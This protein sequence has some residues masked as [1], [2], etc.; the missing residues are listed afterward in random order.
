[1][2]G[3]ESYIILTNI[4]PAVQVF[5]NEI[6]LSVTES[7]MQAMVTVGKQGINERDVLV[8]VSAVTTAIDINFMA[9]GKV[10]T[11]NIHKLCYLFL[12]SFEGI[13]QI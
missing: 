7:A 8:L 4:I 11:M 1:M 9:T 2:V 12:L 6:S 10:I 3:L 5:F 13:P